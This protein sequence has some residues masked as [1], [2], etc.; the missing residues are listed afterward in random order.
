MKAGLF[1][2][3]TCDKG[4]QGYLIKSQKQI[5]LNGWWISACRRTR[6]FFWESDLNFSVYFVYISIGLVLKTEICHQ[7]L[8]EL[9]TIFYLSAI[10]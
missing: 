8:Q 7:E 2:G 10:P 5:I 3:Q 6:S 4:K 1:G 9:K